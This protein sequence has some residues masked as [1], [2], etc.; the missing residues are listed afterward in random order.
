[1][2]QFVVVVQILIAK[3]NSKHPL[4]D[5]RHHLVLNKFRTPHIVKARRKP[6][7]HPDGAIRRAQ[8]QR[9]GIRRD[10]ARVKRRDHCAAF[11]GAKF[12]QFRATLCRHRVL[13]KSSKI[14]CSTT[15]L[16]EFA[17]PMRLVV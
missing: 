10:R 4:A 15:L 3:R 1:M 8:Q 16:A 12:K 9:S 5:Q 7:H 13:R 17:A 14:R 11:H 2:T 6:I